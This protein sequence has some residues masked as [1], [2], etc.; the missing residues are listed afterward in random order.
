ML[1]KYSEIRDDFCT[2]SLNVEPM[3]MDKLILKNFKT[4]QQK[5]VEFD[6]TT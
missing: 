6:S 1:L 2:F 4:G 5:Y 3:Q